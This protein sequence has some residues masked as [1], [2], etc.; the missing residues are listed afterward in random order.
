MNTDLLLVSLRQQALYLPAAVP[1]TEATPAALALCA[2]LRQ[3]GYTVSEQLLHALSS[4]SDEEHSQLLDVLNK[5]MGTHLNW[6]ALVRGWQVPT[7]ETV[8]DHFIT[9][10]ANLLK[11]Q[12]SLRG[13]TLP[14]GH[15]IPDGTFP[16]ERYTGCPFC[17][18]PFKTDAGFVYKGQG[19]KLKVLQLWDDHDLDT[20]FVHLLS[21]SVPL[22]ASQRESLKLLVANRPLPPVEITM[23]ETRMLIIDELVT[24]GR[25]DEAARFFA[26]PQDVMRYLWYRHTGHLQLLEPHTL[27]Y[28]REKNRRHCRSLSDRHD[29]DEA[30]FRQ[31]LRLKYNRQWCRRVARWLNGLTMLLDS[32]LEA[33]HPK[34]RMWVRFIR[35]LRLAEYARHPDYAQLRTLLDRFY[36]QDYTV[37]AGQVDRARNSDSPAA[38]LALLQQRPGLFARSLFSTMLRY[39][40]DEVIE[41]FHTV[42]D[43]VPSRLLYS[44]AAQAQL[45]FDPAGSRVARPLSGTLKDIP[46]HPLLQHYTADQLQHMQQ[47]VC[48]IFLQSM[49]Q[50]YATLAQSQPSVAQRVYIDPRLFDIPMPV[51]DRSATINDTGAALQGTRFQ[52]D[53]DCLRL[54]MQWG[55]D[56]PA[57]PLDMDLSCHLLKDQETV[58]CAYF[59]LDVPGAKHSGDIREIPDKVGTAEYIE[60]SLPE[61]QAAEVRQVVFTC[62]AY[63]AGEL[64]PGLVVGWMD[65]RYPMQVS[66]ETGVAYD[67]STVSHMVRISESNLSKGLIFGVLDVERREITWLEIPFDGKTVL[68]VNTQTVAAY[69]RRLRSKPTIGQLL[70]MRAEAQ[71]QSLAGTP[72]EADEAFTYQWALDTARVCNLLLVV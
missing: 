4:L 60:L 53:G 54:F 34:R 9:Y 49:R 44:L 42:A 41:A 72:E 68:S 31:E 29:D 19:S 40:A 33:M 24:L 1:A 36:R 43:K 22:D 26:S 17:G 7:G 50:R 46:P 71:K 13:I 66:N 63:S 6:A 65:S 64:S 28:V 56:L 8:A 37:W 18:R 58:L 15:L 59:S 35:A 32:Q 52:I 38:V 51:G 45:Y 25:D 69:L 67:P 57:Q 14:C 27:L 3:L 16:L 39:G 70:L 5:V 55:R 11:G 61:L 21:S 10:I 47:T 62:N 12:V 30:T 48:D 23:K 20:H 2:E